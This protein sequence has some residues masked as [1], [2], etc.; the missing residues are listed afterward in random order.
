VSL[1]WP[2]FDGGQRS[3]ESSRLETEA[4]RLRTAQAQ[5]ALQA[6]RDVDDAVGAEQT[7]AAFLAEVAAQAETG[8]AALDEAKARYQRG[9]SDYTPVL[10]TLRILQDAE[11]ARIAAEGQLLAVRV[12]LHE[13]LPGS[14]TTASMDAATGGR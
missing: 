11:R 2:V 12:R 9:L 3:L 1:A 7:T 14:W 13:V 8:Q 10:T 6:T 5:I 4:R